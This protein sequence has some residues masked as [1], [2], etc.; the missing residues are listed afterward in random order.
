VADGQEAITALE[1]TP[2]DLVLMDVQMPVMD[3]F[4]ATQAIRSGHTKARRPDLPIIAMTAH[5]MEGDRDRCLKAGMDD[6][7]S[8]P[9]ALLALAAALE[10]WLARPRKA[11]AT[12]DDQPRRSQPAP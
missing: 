8:K 10:R 5:A 6:Y 3:G 1:T 9:V 4:A 2:Y 11:P 12:E 7:V